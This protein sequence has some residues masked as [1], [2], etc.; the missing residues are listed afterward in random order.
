MTDAHMTIGEVARWGNVPT[1]T[2]RYYESI[3]ILPVPKRVSGQRRYSPDIL[4]I[5]A[6]IQLAK[7]ATFTLPEIKRLL[8]E[9]PQDMSL[10][11]RFRQ[12][13]R[14]KLTEIEGV[15]HEAQT[16]QQLLQEALENPYLRRELDA[17]P[18]PDFEE[19]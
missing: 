10:S 1:S 12:I 6:I 2:L 16:K 9:F 14:D 8:C 13:A 11:E 19:S 7:D 4:P 18:L 15:I 17:T 5:L 3:G